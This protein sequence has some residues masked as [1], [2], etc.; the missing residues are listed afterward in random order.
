VKPATNRCPLPSPSTSSM[1]KYQT[2]LENFM[3]LLITNS[4]SSFW[5]KKQINSKK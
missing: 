4:E 5:D 2:T 1:S 3:F